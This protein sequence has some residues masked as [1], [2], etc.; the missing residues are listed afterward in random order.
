MS[1]PQGPSDEI[2][3]P[4]DHSHLELDEDHSGAE[5]DDAEAGDHS[6]EMD[7]EEPDG[8]PQLPEIGR[9]ARWSVSSHR[10]GF[11]VENLRDGN[12]MTFWQ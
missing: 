5:A 8:L 2:Y 4:G 11:G 9:L 3:E 10:Y 1:D 6:H 12:D 7:D